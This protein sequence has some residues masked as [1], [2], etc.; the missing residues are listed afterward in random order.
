MFPPSISF[1]FV[2]SCFISFFFC[3]FCFFCLIH[4]ELNPH[5][6][7][8]LTISVRRGVLL[9]LVNYQT[10][11]DNEHDKGE[12]CFY[13]GLRVSLMVLLSKLLFFARDINSRTQQGLS[14]HTCTCE[15]DMQFL[16]QSLTA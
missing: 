13:F 3:F 7:S 1:F 4:P 12:L 5:A 8:L 15:L 9:Q 2:F 11:F 6:C 10:I 16:A 14:H